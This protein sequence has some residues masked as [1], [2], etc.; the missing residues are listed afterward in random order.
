MAF[1]EP[2]LA[3]KRAQSLPGFHRLKVLL[4]QRQVDPAQAAASS[5]RYVTFFT[6]PDQLFSALAGCSL[7]CGATQSIWQ[8]DAP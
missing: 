8:F 3:S 2:R 1:I 6:L 7:G 4:E 5:R